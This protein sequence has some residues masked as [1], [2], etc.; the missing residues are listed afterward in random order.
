M[1]YEYTYNAFQLDVM[2]NAP[3]Q[4]PPC[5]V[6]FMRRSLVQRTNLKMQV[7]ELNLIQNKLPLS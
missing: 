4:T 1:A 5:R 3:L 7:I 6:N 2:H